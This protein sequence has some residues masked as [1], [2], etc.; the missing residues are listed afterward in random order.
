MIKKTIVSVILGV[1]FA[2]TAAAVDFDTEVTFA[3]SN[4]QNGPTGRMFYNLGSFDLAF[5]TNL[6]YDNEK[7]DINLELGVRTE[8]PLLGES[9]VLVNFDKNSNDDYQ[10]TELT[11]AKTYRVEIANGLELGARLTLL[12]IG[13]TDNYVT[14]LGSI[15]PVIALNIDLF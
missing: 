5:G 2:T 4:Y 1:L 3:G 14:V 15:E 11:V 12:N 13:L 8:L 9:A 10:A 6:K 7:T